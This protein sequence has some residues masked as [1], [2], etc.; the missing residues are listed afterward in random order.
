MMANL[1]SGKYIQ[2]RQNC[3]LHSVSSRR[4]W[5]DARMRALMLTFVMFVSVLAALDGVGTN[6]ATT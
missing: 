2:T 1:K 3:P 5:A 6:E 4:T